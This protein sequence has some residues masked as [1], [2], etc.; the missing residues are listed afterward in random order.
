MSCVWCLL[1]FL[2]LFSKHLPGPSLFVCFLSNEKQVGTR[3]C[4]RLQGQCGEK[5][6]RD[7]P[8][9]ALFNRFAQKGMQSEQAQAGDGDWLQ[10]SGKVLESFLCTRS[11]VHMGQINISRCFYSQLS[12]EQADGG[13]S[14]G[15]QASQPEHSQSW[16]PG[17]APPWGAV[18]SLTLHPGPTLPCCHPGP[19]WGLLVARPALPFSPENLGAYALNWNIKHVYKLLWTKG[20]FLWIKLF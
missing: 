1:V 16:A 12:W 10:G 11:S 8:W 18:P 2:F 13:A 6:D 3:L 19:R 15:G 20:H 9:A 17:A 4:D 5:T 7:L 14:P